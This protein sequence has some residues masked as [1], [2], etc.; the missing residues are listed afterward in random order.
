MNLK[1][2]YTFAGKNNEYTLYTF[3]LFHI[4]TF[5]FDVELSHGQE[6]YMVLLFSQDM[7]VL[8][9]DRKKCIKISDSSA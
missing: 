5:R 8:C 9:S 2:L 7:Y 4:D 3:M 6:A 1:A